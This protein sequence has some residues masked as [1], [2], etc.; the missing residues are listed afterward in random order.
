MQFEGVALVGVIGGITMRGDRPGGYLGK[1]LV[2][3]V[4]AAGTLQAT[5]LAAQDRIRQ[6][7]RNTQGNQATVPDTDNG[8]GNISFFAT[9]E[10]G[11]DSNLDNRF[12]SHGSPFDL[13]Q[14]GGSGAYKATDSSAYSFY[15]S[16][17]DYWYRDLDL[18][19]RYDVDAAVGARY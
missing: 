12:V 6:D 10:S 17:R 18:S 7:Q 19:Q 2:T 13:I 16:G 4:C 11:F 3:L 8:S 15:L 5:E 14:L 9:T 1:L